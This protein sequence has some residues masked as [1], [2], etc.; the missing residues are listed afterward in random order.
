[1]PVTQSGVAAASASHEARPSGTRDAAGRSERTHSLRQTSGRGKSV[2]GGAKELELTDLKWIRTL[3]PAARN[4]PAVIAVCDQAWQR[5]V[6]P[7]MPLAEARSMAVPL[8]NQRSHQSA[9]RSRSQREVK[10]PPE[11]QFREWQPLEDRAGLISLAELTRRFSPV[12][13]LD[14]MPAPDCLILEITGCGPLFGGESAL[15]E[16]LLRTMQSNGYRCRVAVTDSIAAA[17]AFAHYDGDV[18]MAPSS[19]RGHI[20][21]VSTP[22]GRDQT[23][24]LP[25]LIMPPGQHSDSMGRLPVHAARLL[26]SDIDVLSQLGLLTI[27]QLL[28]LPREDLPSR[29][30][31]DGVRRVQQLAG[32]DD[33]LIVPIP[34]SSPIEAEWSSEFPASQHDE[35]LQ[36]LNH[37]VAQMAEQ[38][39]SHHVGCIRLTGE[40]HC[41]TEGA[42]ST[43]VSLRTQ[44]I[45]NASTLPKKEMRTLI[46]E[47]VK[48]TQ[49]ADLLMDVLSLRLEAM[50]LSLSVEKIHLLATTCPLPTARQKDLFDETQH[51]VPSDELATL[52]SR[53]NGR[54][55]ADA[56]LVA[57]QADDVRPEYSVRL[58]PAVPDLQGATLSL[59]REDVVHQLATPAEGDGRTSAVTT[60]LR[61]VRLLSAPF[62]LP[63][64]TSAAL[65]M[66]GI[67]WQGQSYRIEQ[68]IG[69]ERLQTAWWHDDAIQRD[70]YRVRTTVGSLFWIYRDLVTNQWWLHGLFD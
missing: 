14:Q 30:S 60:P 32:L 16:Q 70:Y 15:A 25:I 33:E 2:K 17:W 11:I 31:I 26:P 24:N 22:A 53:L 62:L 21:S 54:L 13:G 48:P 66:E 10:T 59:N 28:D 64:R 41:L 1:M 56:V 50:K 51:V 47:T 37:L 65:M 55:G 12:T 6:R 5:G 27:R 46:V 7:G 45:E 69:P 49:A 43:D 68:I 29:L 4:G 8:L 52:I 40:L 39:V 44:S 58:T 67:Q 19:G 3:F 36:V 20:R 38:F 42:S 35:I 63:Q 34:E 61:P 57:R 18:R 23:L 9:G